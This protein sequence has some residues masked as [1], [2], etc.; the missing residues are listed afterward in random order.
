MSTENPCLSCGAC[1]A[2]F[3]VSFYWGECQS[4]GGLVPDNLT[5][6]VT[7]H[8]VAM[9][10]TEQKPAR[11]AA[12]LGEVGCGTRCT[13]Y[14]NRSST[15]RE[16]MAAWENGEPN[17]HCDAARAAHGLPPLTPPLQPHLSPDRVA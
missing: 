3:R 1:C 14:E 16:F 6:A 2:Y 13:I 5:V 7:P 10:G 17:P 11:C 4:A 8:L 15:C 12:L 9:Q